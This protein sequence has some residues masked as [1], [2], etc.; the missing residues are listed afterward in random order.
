MGNLCCCPTDKDAYS[1]NGDL[2]ER[3]HLLGNPVSSNPPIP[4][5]P[6]DDLRYPG[7]VPKPTDEQSALNKIL[8]QTATNVI[9]VAALDSHNLEQ[10]EYVERARQYIQKAQAAQ[11]VLLT[12]YNKLMLSKHAGV[13][14]D[15]AAVENLLTDPPIN[16]ED[17]QM[18]MNGSTIISKALNGIK[19]EHKEDLVVPFAIP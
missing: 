6:Y 14:R 18:M 5:T 11:P 10:H 8:Q 16:P 19:I 9:D 3:T 17:Y 15:V 13:L 4:R 2:N 1:Q 7:S 12:K